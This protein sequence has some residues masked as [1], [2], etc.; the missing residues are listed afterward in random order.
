MNR[1]TFNIGSEK[2][3]ANGLKPVA[4]EYLDC[5]NGLVRVK[6]TKFLLLTAQL[7]WFCCLFKFINF[8]MKHAPSDQKDVEVCKVCTTDI[9]LSQLTS[10]STQVNTKGTLPTLNGIFVKM[11]IA[12]YNRPI[13]T[14]CLVL[15]LCVFPVVCWCRLRSRS[16][17]YCAIIFI[18]ST[19]SCFVRSLGP[20][21]SDLAS[22]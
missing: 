18:S 12:H 8:A 2:K 9:N 21:L 3:E 4:I 10:P 15:C 19:I 13:Y 6:N 16:I 5:Y 22:K 17:I 11:E 1:K 20:T 7:L 14:F